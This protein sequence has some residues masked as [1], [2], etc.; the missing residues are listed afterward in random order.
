MAPTPARAHGTT[1]PTARNL[2]WTATPKDSLSGS[3]AAME[4]VATIGV[5]ERSRSL[6]VGT[7]VEGLADAVAE[8]VEAE[9]GEEDRHARE[10]RHPPCGRQV[11]LG[12][13]KHR[14]PARLA[15]RRPPAPHK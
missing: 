4:K 5:K 14:A 1:E 12:L 13:E 3:K 11:G 6:V 10:E 8:E 15:G 7:G 2:D 9:D